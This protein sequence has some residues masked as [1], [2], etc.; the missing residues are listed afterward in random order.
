MKNFFSDASGEK[1]TDYSKLNGIKNNFKFFINNNYNQKNPFLQK[2]NFPTIT[3]TS[4]VSKNANNNIN[5]DEKKKIFNVPP[6]NNDMAIENNQNSEMII[7]ENQNENKNK[8]HKQRIKDV[9]LQSKLFGELIESQRI[10]GEEE[11]KQRKINEQNQKIINSNK[12]FFEDNKP[13]VNIPE[14]KNQINQNNINNNN[15][16]NPFSNQNNNGNNKKVNNFPFNIILS[17]EINQLNNNINNKNNQFSENKID[18]KDKNNNKGDNKL[19]ESINKTGKFKEI[20]GDGDETIP[21]INNYENQNQEKN[22]YFSFRNNSQ[23]SKEDN[24]QKGRQEVRNDNFYNPTNQN[25]EV[26]PPQRRINIS[27]TSFIPLDPKLENNENAINNLKDNL[28]PFPSEDKNENSQNNQEIGNM[29]DNKNL[30]DE[31][32]KGKNEYTPEKIQSTS[33]KVNIDPY[34]TL[35]TYIPEEED[36]DNSKN[37]NNKLFLILLLLFGAAAAIFLWRNSSQLREWL[38]NLLEKM[39]LKSIW[40]KIKGILNFH[41]GIDMGEINDFLERYNDSYRLL[42]LI[43]MIIGFWVIIKLLWKIMKRIFRH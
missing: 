27:L 20:K 41:F 25:I 12:A 18:I 8:D 39:D 28:S 15:L 17:S 38:K 21:I 1:N 10:D 37:H 3:L 42:G 23:N 40:E 33:V 43:V 26:N 11:E 7:E 22:I 30:N 35:P 24:N 4:S 29:E 13:F 31:K 9:F 2:K 19:K 34:Y 32:F 6:S 5:I 14:K 16:Y 36:Q